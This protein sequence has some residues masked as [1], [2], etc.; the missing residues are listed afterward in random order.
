MVT[1]GVI[2]ADYIVILKIQSESVKTIELTLAEARQI[3]DELDQIL[4]GKVNVEG[5]DCKN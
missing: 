2:R 3:R 1:V 5:S 4:R